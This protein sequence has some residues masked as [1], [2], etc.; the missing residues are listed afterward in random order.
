VD[1]ALLGPGSEVLGF[2]TQRSTDHDWGPWLQIFL[3][4]AGAGAGDADAGAG[5]AGPVTAMLDRRL[6]AAYRG[7]PVAFPVT[8]EP[9]GV[10]RH[11]YASRRK[12]PFPAGAPK[13]ATS[14][15]PRSSRPG[16]SAT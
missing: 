13:R 4:D 6:P 2:D 7:Y 10:A 14:S 9:D 16:W 5:D 8:R 3:D 15:A 12:R 11:R 1:A